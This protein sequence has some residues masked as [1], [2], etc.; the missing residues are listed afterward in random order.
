MLKCI[1]GFL[2][3]GIVKENAIIEELQFTD[4]LLQYSLTCS[5]EF[6]VGL[7]LG[8]SVAVNGVCQTVVRIEGQTIWFDAIEETLKKTTLGDLK[9]GARIHVE[10]SA[11]VGDEIGGHI[12]SGHVYGTAHLVDVIENR[13]TF[14]CLPEWT[15]YLFSKGY[16]AIDG[17]SLTL[18]D[19]DRKEGTF[20]VHLIPETL[21]RT[22]LGTKKKG[23]RINL[24]WDTTTQTIVETMERILAEREAKCAGT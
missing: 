15:K 12:L 13:Y 17:I 1:G 11:K 21:A 6:L 8:A 14:G 23:D 22:T 4:A 9:K 3:T 18:V 20:S 10:R 2:F 7:E 24:E 5:K 16:V 19:V